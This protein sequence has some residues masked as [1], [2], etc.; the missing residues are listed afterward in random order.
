MLH[1]RPYN[2]LFENGIVA[3]G[4]STFAIATFADGSAAAPSVKVGDEQNGLYSPAA[5]QLGLALNGTSRMVWT[6]DA[7]GINCTPSA[8]VSARY[9]TQYSG[10]SGAGPFS[11]FPAGSAAD[12]SW[13]LSNVYFDGSNWKNVA[14][15]SSSWLYLGSALHGGGNNSGMAVFG[16]NSAAAG[17]SVSTT[18]LLYV[19]KGSAVA[20]EGAGLNTGTG[21]AFPGTQNASS[22]ANTLDDYEEGTWTPGLFFNSAG[23]DPTYNLREGRYVKVG[24]LVMVSGKIDISA[25]GTRTGT[26]YI[27]GLPFTTVTANSRGGGKVGYFANLALGTWSAWWMSESGSTQGALWAMTSAAVNAATM[28]DTSFTATSV[29]HFYMTYEASA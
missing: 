19:A 25:K 5:N 2:Y 22:D 12:D 16:C 15:A 26:A 9:A 18:A 14:A 3:G 4:T 21:I 27:S 17:S 24:K 20:L 1:D 13:L 7:L 11:I 6:P 8:W 10:A 23:S 28:F 29:L